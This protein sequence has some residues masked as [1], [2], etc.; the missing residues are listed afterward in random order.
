MG[1]ILFVGLLAVVA[2]GYGFSRP[3]LSSRADSRVV[4]RVAYY[5]DPMHPSYKSDKPGVAPDCGMKLVPV[6]EGNELTGADPASLVGEGVTINANTRRLL[7]IQVVTVRKSATTRMAHFVGRVVPEDTRIY[8]V[9]SGVD[10]FIRQ[11]FDDSVGTV[12]KK[13]RKLATYYAPDFLAAAS[14]FLAATERVPGSVGKDGAKFTPNFPGTIAKEGARSI[15]GYTDHLRN[16]GMS[17]EQIKRIADNGELPDSIDVVAPADGL[18]LSR[19]VSPGQHFDHMKEFYRIADLSRVWV[20]AEVYEQEA[21]Y[22]H[23][24]G[25]AQIALRDQGR[26]LMARISDSVPQFEPG[27]GTAKLRLEADN[28]SYILRP[29]M[30]VDVQIPVQLPVALTVPVDAVINSGEHTRV[31]VERSDGVFDPR[32]V[33]TGWRTAE[34][35]EI[36]RGL[37]PGERVVAAA[38]FLVDSESRLRMSTPV[39][40]PKSAPDE[41]IE[42]HDHMASAKPTRDS[43]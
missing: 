25:N 36:V 3:Y 28:P 32:E 7:G 38:T 34:D 16:L 33:S 30:L 35:V 29:D 26:H 43:M 2:V 8:S 14:G 4:P 5:V 19:N 17:D 18:I 24:G 11:T 6:Y 10:G 22:L 23:P 20:V 15:Q 21:Q 37:Q 42:M 13:N 41:P 12:V 9:N 27:G 1:R 31:Y 40:A 39:P